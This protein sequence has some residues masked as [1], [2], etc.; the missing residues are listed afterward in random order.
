MQN[1][2][3]N[4]KI[5]EKDIIIKNVHKKKS[6]LDLK[7]DKVIKKFEKNGAIIFREF[8]IDKKKLIKFTDLFTASYANDAVRRKRRFNEQNI[9]DVDIGTQ[10]VKLH[11]ETSFSPA[12]PE[13]IWFFCVMPPSNKS[14]ST[15]LCDG[16]R[17]WNNLSS[18]TKNFFLSNP[19]VYSLKVPI[20]KKIKSK[21]GRR[22]WYLNKIGV[23]NCFIN[24]T[25][26]YIEF[27]YINFAVVESRIRDQLC[28]TNHLFV[29]LKSE[30]QL[31]SRKMLFSK[32]IPNEIL[33]EINTKAKQMTYKINWKKSD[34]VM[35]DNRRFLHGRENVKKD[36]QRDIVVMQSA[37]A[38]FGYGETTK[39]KF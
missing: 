3:V 2:L 36:D 15:L 12:C 29:T 4:N 18:K 19:V 28:F 20:E 6:L 33:S 30:P 35:I 17:L 26:G 1:F 22:P 38:N 9:Y 21:R 13:I 10:A 11:S 24:W 8:D 27:D 5:I 34:L 31:K 16:L 23:K 7:R 14:G 37:T 32:S 39:K 25:K